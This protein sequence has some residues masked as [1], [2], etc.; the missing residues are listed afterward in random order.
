MSCQRAGQRYTELHEGAILLLDPSASV[1]EEE[2]QTDAAWTPTEQRAAV[3]QC[4]GQTD[5]QGTDLVLNL[6]RA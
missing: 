6:A 4:K 2:R 3:G 1:R 5:R